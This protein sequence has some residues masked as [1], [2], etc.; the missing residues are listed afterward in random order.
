ML[1]VIF[2][3]EFIHFSS[4]MRNLFTV[5]YAKRGNTWTVSLFKFVCFSI[6]TTFSLFQMFVRFYFRVFFSC[7]VIFLCA[8]TPPEDLPPLG[9][10]EFDDDEDDDIDDKSED[11]KNSQT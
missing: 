11:S 8:D 7:L 10:E 1:F 4:S 6:F 3:S 9:D 2:C 5:R